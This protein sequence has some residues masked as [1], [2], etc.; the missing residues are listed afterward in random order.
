MTSP[1][2]TLSGFT[3]EEIERAVQTKL[4]DFALSA[5]EYSALLRV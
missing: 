5:N 3:I 2:K 1:E 4:V